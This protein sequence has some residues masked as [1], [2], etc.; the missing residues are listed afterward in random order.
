M[1]RLLKLVI[2]HFD[3]PS[4]YRDNYLERIVAAVHIGE[5]SHV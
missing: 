1:K 5:P 4:G 3:K 2:D